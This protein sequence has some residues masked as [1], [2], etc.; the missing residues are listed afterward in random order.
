MAPSS[1]P[2]RATN[3]SAF[4]Q[5]TYD[6][7]ESCNEPLGDGA[8]AADA[9]FEEEAAA[10]ALQLINTSCRDRIPE[11]VRVP[12]GDRNFTVL[13]VKLCCMVCRYYNVGRGAEYV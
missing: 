1:S 5:M 9:A 11:I 10:A 4:K 12:S 13:Q 3:F 6:R 2:N 7:G 8:T